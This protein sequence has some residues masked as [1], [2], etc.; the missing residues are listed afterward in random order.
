MFRVQLENGLSLIAYISGEIR[1]NY[2]RILLGDSVAVELSL[3][4]LARGR[5]IYRFETIK[6]IMDKIKIKN[7]STCVN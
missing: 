7:E 2:I 1:R 5:I 3:Y 4:N 6:T